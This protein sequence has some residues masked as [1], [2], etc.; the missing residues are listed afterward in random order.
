MLSTRLIG[1]CFI[2]RRRPRARIAPE[3]YFGGTSPQLRRSAIFSNRKLIR[4]LASTITFPLSPLLHES[5]SSHA[6]YFPQSFTQTS[7]LFS[8]ALAITLSNNTRA[9]P[10]RSPLQDGELPA[11]HQE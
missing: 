3:R 9:T 8:P 10:Y 7:I 2:H 4:A 1:P 11:S 6:V 5:R